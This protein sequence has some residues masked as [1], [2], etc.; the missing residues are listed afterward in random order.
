MLMIIPHLKD[1]RQKFC[2]FSFY[3]WACQN[4]IITK[5]DL[6]VKS[7]IKETIS[8][9]IPAQH[10]WQRHRPVCHILRILGLRS[11]QHRQ[12]PYASC[13]QMSCRPLWRR[14][15]IPRQTIYEFLTTQ[16][17]LCYYTSPTL[18]QLA[19][20]A[21][22]P[23]PSRP[24]REC[25]CSIRCP[26]RSWNTGQPNIIRTIAQSCV[27]WFGHVLRRLDDHPTRDIF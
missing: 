10:H 27:R 23:A 16:P 20:T 22:S 9:L 25:T 21:S 14:R 24:S 7:Q 3:K 26:I 15:N 5:L 17:S 18:S 2:H 1:F 12:P 8:K 6:K 13:L 11:F 19:S 4:R